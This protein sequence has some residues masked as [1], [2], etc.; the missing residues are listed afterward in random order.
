MMKLVT[1]FALALPLLVT[2]SCG[3][4]DPHEAAAKDAYS[5]MSDFV[6][7]LEGI[8]DKA[9]AEASK[10][11]LEK[12]GKRMNELEARMEELGEPTAEKMAAIEEKYD[13]EELGGRLMTEM[14][15]LAMDSEIGPV[16]QEVMQEVQPGG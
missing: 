5:A 7:V 4:G 10:A 9:S 11:E 14:M 2:T 8:T 3:G 13:M 6:E 12:V 1:L 16:L 15:R